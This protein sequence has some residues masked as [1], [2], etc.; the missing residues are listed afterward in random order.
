[1]VP[2]EFS[3]DVSVLN[4]VLHQFASFLGS[5]LVS[6]VA[7]PSSLSTVTTSILDDGW[8][9]KSDVLHGSRSDVFSNGC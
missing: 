4:F 8:G 5:K 3:N 9:N 7:A 1:M 2:K 6:V